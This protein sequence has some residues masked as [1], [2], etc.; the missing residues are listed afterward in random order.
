MGHA[1]RRAPQYPRQESNLVLD[2]RTV[3]CW[4]AHPEDSRDRRAER[5]RNPAV[6]RG[7]VGGTSRPPRRAGDI[8]P[9]TPLDAA[10][11]P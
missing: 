11:S 3:V 10:A 7:Q 2:L 8:H 9:A 1:G 6:A 4:P 5:R